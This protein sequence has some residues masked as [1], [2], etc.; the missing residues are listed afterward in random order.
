MKA[1]QWG[2]ALL[3]LAAAAVPEVDLTVSG[4]FFEPPNRFI[5]RYFPPF[6]FIRRETQEAVGFL[7]L[8]VAQA[9]L[10]G[11]IL[12]KTLLG[13]DGRRCLYLLGSLALGPG[14]VV[15]GVLKEFWGRAR[16]TTVREFGGDLQFSPALIPSDQCSHNC[17][18]VSGHAAAAFW[19]VSFAL[20]VPPRW[21]PLAVAVALGCGGAMGLVRV[22][23]GGHF[24]SD[25]V[26]AGAVTF[27]VSLG[28]RRL[29]L[30][31]ESRP[32]P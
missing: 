6:E 13:I 26:Y 24:L 9:W 3:I 25:V 19:L 32:L 12:G 2:L 8:V 28:M 18:F 23:Q 31:P 17:S 29:I 16:P 27:I 14:L 15:N 5:L 7:A 11:R 10:A 22:A 21:R 30:G 1:P 20:L 4:W